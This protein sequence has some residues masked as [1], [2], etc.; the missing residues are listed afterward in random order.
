M[1]FDLLISAAGAALILVA[2][3]DVF[4]TLWHPVGRGS[5]STLVMTGVWR[6]WGRASR[7]RARVAVGLAVSG[8]DSSSVL[9]VAP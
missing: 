4:H 7:S 6:C 5:L 2:L 8:H 3:R 9:G 1:A